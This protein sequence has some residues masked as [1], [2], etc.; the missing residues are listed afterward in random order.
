MARRG[1]LFHAGAFVVAPAP[2]AL[3]PG[4]PL[5]AQEAVP[6]EQMKEELLES[7]QK[8]AFSMRILYEQ[9]ANIQKMGPVGQ[10]MGMIPG[11]SNAG[12]KARA[13]PPPAPPPCSPPP[14]RP[15]SR[16]CSLAP[17]PAPSC[18]TPAAAG[19]AGHW[20]RRRVAAARPAGQG[21]RERRAHQALHVHDGQHDHQGA[22]QPQPQDLGRDVAHHAHR[23]R[24]RAPP[25]R[26]AGADR[27]GP[28][29]AQPYGAF[30]A[31]C[32]TALHILLGRPRASASRRE[33]LR[34]A[35]RLQVAWQAELTGLG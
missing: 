1:A 18:S 35:L 23:A 14:L 31:V 20:A 33:P 32:L 11:L 29:L 12:V 30:P 4:R 9:F 27:C 28:A 22:G 13:L 19:S 3:R 21:E 25:D 26:G 10:I 34:R 24:L 2:G 15:C 7:M 5:P 6:E 8:G 17:L 16:I